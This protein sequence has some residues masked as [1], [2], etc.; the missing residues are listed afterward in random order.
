[1]T[2]CTRGWPAPI[3]RTVRGAGHAGALPVG[4]LGWCPRAGPPQQPAP[5]HLL[6][7]GV[8][9]PASHRMDVIALC[10]HGDA[11]GGGGA[12]DHR[13]LTSMQGGNPG[14]AVYQQCK[15]A[16]LLRPVRSAHDCGISWIMKHSH[17]WVS[18]QCLGEGLVFT[19]QGSLALFPCAQPTLH[20][21]TPNAS[22]RPRAPCVLSARTQ[23]SVGAHL[24]YRIAVGRRP[25]G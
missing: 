17:Y 24:R 2:R 3:F 16:P 11:I 25:W 8:Q 12:I 21:V 15:A 19:R 20:V 7:H 1:M 13:V 4:L 5:T 18:D 23:L 14:K 22:H 9:I 6:A 10:H